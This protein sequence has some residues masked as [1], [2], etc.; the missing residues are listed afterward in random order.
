MV[1]AS[2]KML[3]E[4]D[5]DKEDA[6]E[7]IAEAKQFHAM[8]DFLAWASNPDKKITLFD[9]KQKTVLTSE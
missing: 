1:D 7:L 6:K 4:H 8:D 9:L 3:S 5:V 2:I